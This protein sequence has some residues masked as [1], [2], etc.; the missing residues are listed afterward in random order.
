MAGIGGPV[1]DSNSKMNSSIWALPRD[2]FGHGGAGGSKHGAWPTQRVGYSYAMNLMREPTNGDP[3]AQT[4][5]TA[6]Y[7][8]VEEC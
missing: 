4:L 8:C 6:L 5:L 2:A 1:S 3:R 7:A